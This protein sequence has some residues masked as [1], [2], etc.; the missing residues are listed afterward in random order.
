MI[1]RIEAAPR[2]EHREARADLLGERE[3]V[4]LD[5]E[6]AVVA[7]LGL[8]EPVEVRLEVGVGRP[9]GAVDPLELRVVLVAAPVR[10]ADVRE[11]ERAEPPGRGH[12]RTAAQVL[13]AVV[14]VEARGLGGGVDVAGRLVGAEALDDLA[15]ER[16][17]G[18]A[19]ER[20]LGRDLLADERLV[21]GDDRAHR[22]LDLGQVV[23][24]DVRRDREVVVEAVGDRGADAELG[25]RPQ[26]G[27]R[28]R[29]DVR[30]RVPQGHGARRRSARRSARPRR[31]R[32]GRTRGRGARRRPARRSRPAEARCRPAPPPGGSPWCRR[33][34][35][36]PACGA[37]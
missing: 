6:L 13:P 16:L 27:D 7:L 17:L 2:M 25:A 1:L 3:Q 20:L 10:A 9:R 34:G 37:G 15:L 14:A 32:R 4:E 21:L 24:R 28:L 12:V 36:G 11:L 22:L 30:G 5:A 18:Q 23:D 33:A 19:A 29:E 26:P 31:H 35:A 8:L